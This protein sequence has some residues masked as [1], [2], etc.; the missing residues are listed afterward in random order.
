M[1]KLGIDALVNRLLIN[2]FTV[3]EESE[4]TKE[5]YRMHN[6]IDHIHE[7]VKHMGG[8]EYLISDTNNCAK[9]FLDYKKYCQERSINPLTQN[10]LGRLLHKLYH[11]TS[12]TAN[13]KD[14]TKRREKKYKSRQ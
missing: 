5:F 2:G 9:I 11:I 10:Q 8:K 3:C 4:Q 1:I 14:G 6:S 7:F 12:Y 13:P